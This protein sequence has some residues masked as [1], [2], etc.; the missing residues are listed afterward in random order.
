MSDN[1]EQC[2][3]CKWYLG[4]M[5]L[6][7]ALRCLAF[8]KEIPREILTGEQ[9]HQT[10]YKGDRGIVW[11]E[12]TRALLDDDSREHR[13]REITEYL[14]EL[15]ELEA[16]P[17][18]PRCGTHT[19]EI[20]YGMPAGP[21]TFR[22]FAAGC[23]I[24]ED[25]FHY[26]WWCRRCNTVIH[27]DLIMIS[28]LAH[29]YS[30]F[31][32]IDKREFQRSSRILQSIWRTERGYD[33]GELKS[34]NGS[35]PLGSRLPMPW[36]RESLGNYLN[37]TIRNVV[38]DEVIDPI[39]SKGKLFSKPRIFD[40]LLSSQPLCFNLFAELKQDL[41]F[42]TKVFKI[43]AP[44]VIGSVTGIEFE[45]SPGM[46][47]LRFTGDRSA[48]DV[49]VTFS[50]RDHSKGFIGIEVK[51]HENLVGRAATHKERYDQVA[52]QMDCFEGSHLEALKKQPLQ[53]IWRD[54]M[55][56]GIH[57]IV[58]GF[59]EG[60]FVFLYPEANTYC[61]EAITTYRQCLTNDYTFRSWTL[62]GVV[63]AIKR[64]TDDGWIDLFVDRYLNYDKLSRFA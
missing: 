12:G 64:S 46:G 3:S 1:T 29:R 62:E 2:M 27:D 18:C 44:D 54:H 10:P 35:R 14:E 47:D 33:I 50:S 63:D 40:D 43:L 60:I 36:A 4:A 7:D 26:R 45:W 58:D 55:L 53:Q 6:N 24:D 28:R 25:S 38:R 16:N 59:E 32:S 30:A 23:V 34:K 57:K 5:G 49:Y 9:Q 13:V 21:P 37:E 52:S 56:A 15:K 48:F 17:P 61:A 22:Y 11:E 20:I 19:H 41:A 42:A 31:E 39:K 8:S 51:Y